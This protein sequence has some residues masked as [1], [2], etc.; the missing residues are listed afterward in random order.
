MLSNKEKKE[1][2]NYQIALINQD[3]VKKKKGHLSQVERDKITILQSEGLS[4]RS[5][6][7]ILDRSAST[8]S[9]ESFQKE[10]ILIQ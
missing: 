5:I 4:I 6:A 10:L 9:R 8:I 2:I 3:K 1:E 7:S